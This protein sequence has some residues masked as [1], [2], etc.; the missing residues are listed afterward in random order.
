MQSLTDE[1]KNRLPI[2]ELVRLLN[3]EIGRN[4]YLESPG[5]QQKSGSVKIYPETNSFWD[6]SASEGGSVIDLYAY[7]Q[8]VDD[9]QAIKDLA[10]ICGLTDG[11]SV[12]L[13]ERPVPAAWR[14]NGKK[15]FT[16]G[17]TEDEM[18]LY[19]SQFGTA[20][21]TDPKDIARAETFMKEF[22]MNSNSE[23][24]AEFERYCNEKGWG[25]LA[26]HY[27]TEKR[28]LP[29]EVVKA[30]RLFF[31]SNYNEVNNHMKKTFELERLKKSGLYN[32]RGN[33]IFYAHRIIIPYLWKGKIVYMRGR[34]FDEQGNTNGDNKYLGL[35][36][37]ATGVN[38]PKRFFNLEETNGMKQGEHLY[39]TEGEFDAMAIKAM[40]F[41]AVAVPGTGNIPDTPKLKPLLPFAIIVCGDRDAAGE[42][43]LDNMIKAFQYWRKDIKVK[44]LP[45][46]KDPND[47]LTA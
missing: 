45:V 13:P 9:G 36:T 4:G 41:H 3:L 22:R 35:R 30:F 11:G 18:V 6:F 12:K 40:G 43:F 16:D 10:R 24:F 5:R 21:Q 42:G 47:F 31:I 26:R 29:F 38:T 7:Y 28:K 15:K 2:M 32:D 33:L 39:I 17:L 46:G 20:V 14:D 8:N 37:D 27:L 34:Y 25:D 1:I 19:D 44:E 23:V